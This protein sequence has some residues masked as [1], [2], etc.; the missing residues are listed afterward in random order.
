MGRTVFGLVLSADVG[1][2]WDALF[3]VSAECWVQSTEYRVQST[4]YKVQSTKYRVQST[5]Y[6]VQSTEYRALNKNVW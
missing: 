2:A 6:K 5:E 3:S 1:S 4:E